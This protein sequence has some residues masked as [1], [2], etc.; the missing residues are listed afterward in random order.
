MK[1]YTL[2]VNKDGFTCDAEFKVSWSDYIERCP[3]FE[4]P[5]EVVKWVEEMQNSTSYG[6]WS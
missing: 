4:T 3:T 6:G 5:Q 2:L 1:S